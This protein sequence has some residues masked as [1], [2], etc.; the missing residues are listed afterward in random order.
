MVLKYSRQS[1]ILWFVAINMVAIIFL[2]RIRAG[3]AHHLRVN[4]YKS[5]QSRALLHDKRKTVCALLI[6]AVLNLCGWNFLKEE[7]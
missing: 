5:A 3:R 4:A 7:I 2:S 6:L 1:H